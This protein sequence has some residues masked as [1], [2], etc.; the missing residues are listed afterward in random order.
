[1]RVTFAILF[2][3]ALSA[4]A[5]DPDTQ[6][7]AKVIAE[8]FPDPS[9]RRGVYEVIPYKSGDATPSLKVIHFTNEIGRADM[10]ARV[11]RFCEERAGEAWTGP[12]RVT[13]S[14]PIREVSFAN[15]TSKSIQDRGY[16]CAEAL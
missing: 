16:S 12:A 3:A 1:M 10:L 6:R 9:D 8:V 11:S 4:C 15:G 14:Q 7:R 13:A 5:S 2:L